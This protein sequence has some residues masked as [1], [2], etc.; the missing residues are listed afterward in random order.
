MRI[1]QTH[2]GVPKLGIPGRIPASSGGGTK[3]E[4]P[5]LPYGFL[6]AAFMTCLFHSDG[7]FPAE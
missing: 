1:M 5:C 4:E 3:A 6:F 7:P 2:V